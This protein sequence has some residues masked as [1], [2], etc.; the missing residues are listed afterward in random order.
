M[1]DVS[2]ADVGIGEVDAIDGTRVVVS[3]EAE[4]VIVDEISAWGVL[5]HRAST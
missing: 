3:R 2:L 4:L 1:Q 5:R